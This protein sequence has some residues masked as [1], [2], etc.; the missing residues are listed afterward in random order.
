MRTNFPKEEY[1][2]I[3]L[4]TFKDNNKCD[5]FNCHGYIG[6]CNNTTLANGQR[7]FTASIGCKGQ[8]YKCGTYDTPE[9]A[10]I[11]RDRKAYELLGDKAKLNFPE[12]I[13]EYKE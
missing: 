7:R 1:A 13:D 3:D 10:A 2:D 8:K 9:E 6:V 12:R 5:V 11:A 4:A